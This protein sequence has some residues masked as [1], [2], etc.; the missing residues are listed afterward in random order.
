MARW[1]NVEPLTRSW[2]VPA[3]LLLV[4]SVDAVF[5]G[6]D[7]R[8]TDVVHTH[9]TLW[10]VMLC[11]QPFATRTVSAFMA[12]VL[13]FRSS[14][15]KALLLLLGLG[16]LRPINENRESVARL[17]LAYMPHPQNPD[18]HDCAL[19]PLIP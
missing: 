17:S 1:S 6:K 13:L 8:K 9:H 18:R 11:P 16:N 4:G 7:K 3:I 12:T 10:T 5:G 15:L 19:P 2:N 14:W